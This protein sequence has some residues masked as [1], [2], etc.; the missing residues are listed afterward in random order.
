MWFQQI[1]LS[2]VISLRY[3][4]IKRQSNSI[5]ALYKH[6]FNTGPSSTLVWW[7]Q[8]PE[9]CSI[10]VIF[11]S[12]TK[13]SHKQNEI[14]MMTWDV[15]RNRVARLKGDNSW[16]LWWSHWT[17]YMRWCVIDT[18]DYISCETRLRIQDPGSL[19]PDSIVYRQEDVICGRDVGGLSRV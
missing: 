10:E 12:F 16:G 17:L 9:W 19:S 18:R 2:Y 3:T 4:R 1:N 7:V 14:R 15:R 5:S 8:L 13:Q 6:F 11:K